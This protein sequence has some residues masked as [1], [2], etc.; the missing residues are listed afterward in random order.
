VGTAQWQYVLPRKEKAN[1]MAP[2][3]AYEV[4]IHKMATD[5]RQL[6]Q[7]LPSEK[8]VIHQEDARACQSVP[9]CWATLVLTS[10]PYTNNYDYADATRLEM[11]FWREVQ[12]WSDLHPKIRRHLI[13]SCTQHVA[14]ERDD[15]DCLLADPDLMPLLNELQSVCHRMAE[16]RMHHGGKK[17]YHVMV[18]AYFSDLAKVWKALRRVTGPGSRICFVVGDSAPYGVHVPVDRWLGELALAAGFR[19]YSFEKTW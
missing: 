8:A 7:R 1:P 13:R 10:P 9:D 19:A 18:A 3:V 14:A 4:Q 17:P 12:N 5:M 11:S 15:L 2:F 6:Q 16:K